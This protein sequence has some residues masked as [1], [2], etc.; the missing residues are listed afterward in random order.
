MFFGFLSTLFNVL[1]AIEDTLMY[2]ECQ[3]PDDLIKENAKRFIR[4]PDSARGIGKKKTTSNEVVCT[5][6][7]RGFAS[8]AETAFTGSACGAR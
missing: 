5:V 7:V 2:G 8:T 1:F 4:F 3:I 6:S